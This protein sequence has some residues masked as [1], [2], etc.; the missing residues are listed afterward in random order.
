MTEKRAA[1]ISFKLIIC[2]ALSLMVL[3]PALPARA[4]VV[5]FKQLMPFVDIKIP[6]WTMKG[7]PSGTTMKH[8]QWKM[9]EAGAKFKADGKTLK[10]HILDFM[11]K[12]NPLNRIPEIEIESSEETVR[13]IDVQ[14]FRALENYHPKKKQG[15]MSITVAKRFIVQIEAKGIDNPKVMQEVVKIMDLKKLAGLAK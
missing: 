12:A 13:T 6:G 4:E 10:I 9:S 2:L 7:K 3:G 5:N 15:N 14:G 8:G 1:K 11:G